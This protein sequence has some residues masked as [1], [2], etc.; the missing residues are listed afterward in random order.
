MVLAATAGVSGA[1][2]VAGLPSAY[3]INPVSALIAGRTTSLAPPSLSTIQHSDSLP[4]STQ[5]DDA[6]SAN[7]GRTTHNLRF[8]FHLQQAL[9]PATAATPV[10]TRENVSTSKPCFQTRDHADSL[11]Y[12]TSTIPLTSSHDFVVHPSFR[13]DA[14][15][16]GDVLVRVEQAEFFVHRHVLVFSSPFFASLLDGEWKESYLPQTS[17]ATSQKEAPIKAESSYE[18]LGCRRTS[19]GASQ[20]RNC[21]EFYAYPPEVDR[22]HSLPENSTGRQTEDGIVNAASASRSH[23]ATSPTSD[24]QCTPLAVPSIHN[25]SDT[26][27]R[28]NSNNVVGETDTDLVGDTVSLDLSAP[29]ARLTR[30]STPPGSP[31]LCFLPSP[32]REEA[33]APEQAPAKP[34]STGSPLQD[35]VAVIDLKEETVSTFQDFLFHVYPHLDLSVTWY[36]CGPL[37]RFADKFQVPYLRRN[38]VLF[39]R[40]A[41]AG[42]PIQAMQLAEL[43]SIDDVYRE[44]SRHVLDNYAA[45]EPEELDCLSSATLLKL[46][47]KRAWFLER[48]LKLC[49]ANPARDYE[50]QASCPDPPACARALHEKWQS[51]YSN[52]FRFSPPQP[53][54]IFRHLRELEPTVHSFLP[55]NACQNS[56][57]V[58]VQGLFDRMFSL[59]TLHAPR[60]FLSI[61]LTDPPYEQPQ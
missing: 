6:L 8:E 11:A 44:A 17:A 48:L 36:N 47:R 31:I 24:T 57:R 33:Q 59:S 3:S 27:K 10:S 22:G 14:R 37:L 60:Q 28:D 39:L 15:H 13:K 45:W 41:L 49:L 29:L 52:A 20:P 19:L 50:C 58:W 21:D 18:R 53:S 9:T 51:A 42:R 46:E 34:A 26:R 54:V 4:A 35:V 32:R 25:V 2:E 30:L 38:C 5:F 1:S 43:N 40:A 61:K 12:R 16:R 7:A 55:S 23:N 56:A